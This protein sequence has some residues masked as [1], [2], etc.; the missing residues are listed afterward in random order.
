MPVSFERTINKLLFGFITPMSTRHLSDKE[1]SD[2]ISHFA[3]PKYLGGYTVDQISIHAGLLLLKPVMR[4][5]KCRVENL[6]LTNDLFFVEY[7]MGIHLSRI[8]GL[9]INNCT[10][11]TFQPSGVY[12]YVMEI[13]HLYVITQGE[14][15]ECSGNK[16]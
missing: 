10:T 14:L 8:Y 5:V 12:K 7:H 16:I 4:Y 3:A 15:L 6:G 11:H 2:K 1:I 13:I 9:K